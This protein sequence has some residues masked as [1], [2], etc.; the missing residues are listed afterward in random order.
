[1]FIEPVANQVPGKVDPAPVLR[2]ACD[3]VNT[4]F[5]WGHASCHHPSHSISMGAVGRTQP[6]AQAHVLPQL[7]TFHPH[8]RSCV[9]VQVWGAVAWRLGWW[10]E[11]IS[12]LNSRK[13][14]APLRVQAYASRKIHRGT[15]SYHGGQFYL[16]DLWG[17]ENQFDNL[18]TGN[19]K[20]KSFWRLAL[21][22]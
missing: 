4:M 16:P 19:K 21:F 11:K 18:W 9:K 2:E 6:V 20:C 13:Q 5:W 14:A 15:F 10:E 7:A 1:M 12:P 22:L 17:L 3:T 8:V